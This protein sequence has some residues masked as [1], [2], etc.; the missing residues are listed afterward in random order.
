MHFAAMID[1]N[2]NENVSK[3][4]KG[5][6]TEY[7]NF[8][9]ECNQLACV[10]KTNLGAPQ[11]CVYTCFG[12]CPCEQSQVEPGLVLTRVEPGLVCTV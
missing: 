4:Y 6:I 7:N 12:I 2:V 5:L 11:V 1:A 10:W 3:Q 8:T 9:C